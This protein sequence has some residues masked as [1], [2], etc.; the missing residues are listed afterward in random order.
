MHCQVS[1][2]A[3]SF[4]KLEFQKVAVFERWNKWNEKTPPRILIF[5]NRYIYN[6]VIYLYPILILYPLVVPLVPLVPLYKN[7]NI[8]II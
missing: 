3:F 8:I 1:A 6:I 4:K 2:I 7:N 5:Y